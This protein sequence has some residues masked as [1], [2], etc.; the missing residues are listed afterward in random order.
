[1][2]SPTTVGA[3]VLLWAAST[4]QAATEID[5]GRYHALVV[6][7]N[8]YHH[9]PKLETAVN[10]ASAVHDLLLH[11]YGFDSTLLLNPGRYEL[12]RALD[13]LRAE[14]TEE[15]NLLIYHAGHGYL[16]RQTD[17][18]FWL[19]ADAEEDSQANWIPVATVTGTLK[20]IPAKH[21]LVIADSCYSGTLSRD[22]PVL[23]GTTAGR[24][25]EHHAKTRTKSV[26]VRRARA[27]R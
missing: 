20:A 16:D 18:G 12:V 10:D 26:D 17:Q 4:A 23:L 2:P 6:G 7:I 25:A 1:M 3:V 22:A 27:G 11:H 8:E 15:D 14:L 21:V 19:P 24:A 9:L 13:A 5:F